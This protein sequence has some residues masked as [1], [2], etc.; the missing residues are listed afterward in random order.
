MFT[1]TTTHYSDSKFFMLKAAATPSHK[2]QIFFFSFHS[3][4]EKGTGI[5]PFRRTKMD[6]HLVL[7][8]KFCLN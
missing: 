3:P 2:I 8:Q 4:N 6:L 5:P 7:K 1:A